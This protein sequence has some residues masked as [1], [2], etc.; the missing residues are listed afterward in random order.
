M[1]MKMEELVREGMRIET[2]IDD[3]GVN[4]SR[5]EPPLSDVGREGEYQG[6]LLPCT[7]TIVQLGRGPGRGGLPVWS[8]ATK[9]F[10]WRTGIWLGSH[11]ASM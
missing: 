8:R 9:L 4:Y 7:L 11:P 3:Q 1:G 10:R 2:R 6:Y 5:S